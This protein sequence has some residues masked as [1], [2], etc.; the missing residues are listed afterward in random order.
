MATTMS[1][2]ISSNSG[3]AK[4]QAMQEALANNPKVKVKIKIKVKNEKPSGNGKDSSK[5]DK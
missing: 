4:M 5:E 2:F 1:N 3:S